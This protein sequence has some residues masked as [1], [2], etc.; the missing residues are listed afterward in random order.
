[1]E[2]KSANDLSN[3]K[4][5]EIIE[6]TVDNFV[7]EVPIPEEMRIL[8]REQ[9]L[10]R[11]FHNAVGARVCGVRGERV[12]DEKTA[13]GWKKWIENGCLAEELP[14]FILVDQFEEWRKDWFLPRSLR[15]CCGLAAVKDKWVADKVRAEGV[16]PASF[17][18]GVVREGLKIDATNDDEIDIRS[19]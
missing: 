6:K 2:Y 15:V 1:M 18:F 19:L 9:E 13:V 4:T 14:E 11:V 12:C 5:E 8:L 3:A 16:T 17:S 10:L 7:T